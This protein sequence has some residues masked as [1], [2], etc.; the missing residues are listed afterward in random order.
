MRNPYETEQ[1]LMQACWRWGPVLHFPQAN[2]LLSKM[3]SD[4][5][6]GLEYRGFPFGAAD[7][8]FSME[9]TSR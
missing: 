3:G 9:T 7:F 4:A 1:S 6:S 8:S 5:I 2:A